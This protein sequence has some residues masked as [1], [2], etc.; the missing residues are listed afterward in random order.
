MAAKKKSAA[1]R[2]RQQQKRQQRRNTRLQK[3]RSPARPAPAPPPLRLDKTLGDDLRLLVPG[4]DLSALTPDRFADL[5]LPPALDSADLV[6]EP[7]FAD[8]AIPPLEATQTYIEVIQEQGIESEDIADLDEEE[9]EEAIAE[10]LDETTARLLTPALRQQLRTGLIDLRARLRRTKQVNE[11]PRVAAVQ[12]FLESDQDGQIIASLGLVQEIV[13]RGI[14]FGFQVAEAIDQLKTAEETDGELTPEALRQQVAQSEALQR[15]TATLEATPG[16]RRFLEEQI[17]ELEDA[18]RRALFEGK[19][20]LD[21]YTEAEIAGA[22]KLFKQATG[23]DPTILLSPDRNLATILRAL[24]SQLV[25]YVRNLFA[26][27]ERLAQL[28][29]RMDEVVADPAF[30]HSQWTPLLLTLH[31]YLGEEDALEYMQGYLVTALFGELWTSV[32]PPEAF[33]VDETDEPD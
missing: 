12:M 30:A 24:M 33:E 2:H 20:R 32:L 31:R 21:L 18:G 26:A 1:Q 6:D 3:Q 17:D 15:L 27:E 22:A 9:R 4:G 5:L 8:I 14:V 13:R 11:L 19:L 23:D 10:A 29:Q 7:E 28:R 16:L 25:E